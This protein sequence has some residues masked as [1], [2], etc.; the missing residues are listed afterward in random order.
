MRWPQAII[1]F[2]YNFRYQIISNFSTYQV[3]CRCQR[4]ASICSAESWEDIVIFRQAKETWLRTFLTLPHGI[5]SK[6]TFRRVFAAL[7]TEDFNRRFFDWVT[8]I[9][10]KIKD[11]VLNIS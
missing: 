7:D 3:G 11:E 1:R 10:P 6:D 5:P 8:I 9:N 2:L 4:Y